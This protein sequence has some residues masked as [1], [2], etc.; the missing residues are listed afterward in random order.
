MKL[1]VRP[2][3]SYGELTSDIIDKHNGNLT[4]ASEVDENYLE[5]FLKASPE[6][7]ICEIYKID[8]KACSCPSCTWRLDGYIKENFCGHCGQKLDWEGVEK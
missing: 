3:L 2:S 5:L 7:V 6:K 8:G 1:V 4:V